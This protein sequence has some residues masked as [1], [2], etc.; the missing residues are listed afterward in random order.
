MHCLAL[1]QSAYVALSFSQILTISIPNFYL[2]A[3]NA[4][5]CYHDMNW[6]CPYYVFNITE[7]IS[8]R[9][10]RTTFCYQ[11]QQNRNIFLIELEII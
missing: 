7:N 3:E 11:R 1:F 10:S 2:F 6:H 8:K 5:R 9:N 4:V